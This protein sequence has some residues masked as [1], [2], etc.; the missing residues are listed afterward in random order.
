MIVPG[1]THTVGVHCG[2]T[3][4]VD[5]LRHRGVEI[6][7]P[8]AFGLG[9]GL[10]FFYLRG[11][12]PSRTIYGRSGKLE[13]EAAE[14]LGFRLALMQSHDPVEG[15]AQVKEKL[16]AGVPVLLQ[17]DLFH[18]GY[19]NARTH[20]NGHRAVIAGY[21]GNDALMADTHFEGLVRVP[22]DKLDEARASTFPPFVEGNRPAWTLERE[23]DPPRAHG[24]IVQSLRGFAHRYL[25]EDNG[26]SGLRALRDFTAEVG[27][28]GALEDAASVG[29][30]CDQVIEKRGTGGALFR[31]LYA[32]FLR[33]AN[34]TAPELGLLPLADRFDTVAARWREIAALL[35]ARRFA[36]A[37][38]IAAGIATDEQSICQ[39]LEHIA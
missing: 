27:D 24:A 23:G 6:T 14:R 10:S 26:F 2:S 30:F 19:Y 25:T 35:G 21:E 8:M 33:E 15:W 39:A 16:D 7:E 20:F 1:F 36:D 37:A 28:F 9:A 11:F 22:L 13:E 32:R 18:L 34:S 5:L 12:Q 29:R 4:M 31:T 17:L 3:A 38:P